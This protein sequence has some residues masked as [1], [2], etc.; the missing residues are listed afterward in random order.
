MI[1]TEATAAPPPARWTIHAPQDDD[2][3][4]ISPGIRA[5][6][7]T[8]RQMLVE[9]DPGAAWVGE[10][11]HTAGPEELTILNGSLHLAITGA[12]NDHHVSEGHRVRAETGTGHAPVAGP[13]GCRLLA[14]YP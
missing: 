12:S 7:I 3:T 5:R 1:T 9:F 10:D 11:T 2:W 4:T 13:D 6:A 14:T 8:T